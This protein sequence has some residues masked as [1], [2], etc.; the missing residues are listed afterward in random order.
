MTFDGPSLVFGAV[1]ATAFFV[2]ATHLIFTWLSW[3]A[4]RDEIERNEARLVAEERQREIADDPKEW[5]TR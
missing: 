2:C 3:R 1:L 5:R 4:E